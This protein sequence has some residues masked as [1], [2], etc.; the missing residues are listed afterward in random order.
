MNNFIFTNLG[1]ARA[2]A[3]FILDRLRLYGH[4]GFESATKAV[5]EREMAKCVT[6]ARRE[7]L[8][9]ELVRLENNFLYW[10]RV[11]Q[12]YRPGSLMPLDFG[13]LTLLPNGELDMEVLVRSVLDIPP[14]VEA[15][16]LIY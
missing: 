3:E 8:R 4:R 12:I 14:F 1:P 9:A 5:F 11:G 6:D 16:Y 15:E 2:R 10:K 7:A 13:N